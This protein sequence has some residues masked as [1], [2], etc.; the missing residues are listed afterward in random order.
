MNA[1]AMQLGCMSAAAM[2]YERAERGGRPDARG[3]WSL[4]GAHGHLQ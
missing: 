3:H 4:P 2:Q 1:A